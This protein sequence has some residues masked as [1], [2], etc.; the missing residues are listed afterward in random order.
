MEGE[1]VWE[2]RRK[3][4]TLDSRWH[5]G[6]MK[7]NKAPVSDDQDHKTTEMKETKVR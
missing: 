1:P 5:E 3:T 6:Q 2:A 4:Q 7:A